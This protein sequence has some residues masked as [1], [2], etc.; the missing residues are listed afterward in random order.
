[1]LYIFMSLCPSGF[2]VK[3]RKD[4]TYPPFF[5]DYDKEAERAQLE[6]GNQKMRKR[7]VRIGNRSYITTTIGS[8]AKY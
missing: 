5:D 2:N 4:E 8:C 1:M 6:E 7:N 3:R